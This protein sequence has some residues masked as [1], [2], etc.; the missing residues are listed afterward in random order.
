MPAPLLLGPEP[1]P[2]V[3]HVVGVVLGAFLREEGL[4]CC[5]GG[6]G[7]GQCSCTA[8]LCRDARILDEVKFSLNIF[9][10]FQESPKSAKSTTKPGSGSSGKDGGTENSEEVRLSPWMQQSVCATHL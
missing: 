9:S 2:W 4:E 7:V 1:P 6:G 5:R 10:S 3:S 8:G